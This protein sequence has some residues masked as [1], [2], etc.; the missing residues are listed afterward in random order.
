M[1]RFIRLFHLPL[2]L[3]ISLLQVVAL[4]RFL[5]AVPVVIG[6]LLE[7]R[8]V[9]EVQ[10]Q[11]CHFFLRRTTACRLAAAEREHSAAPPPEFKAAILC[12][13]RLHRLVV[14]VL[15]LEAH[16]RRVAAVRVV[17]LGKIN[18]LELLRHPLKDSS[19]VQVLGPPMVAVVGL[20]KQAVQMEIDLEAMVSPVQLPAHRFF[21]VAVVPRITPE[22]V[23]VAKAA[24]VQPLGR[25]LAKTEPSIQE[26]VEAAQML[27]S[28]LLA[29]AA[30]ASSFCDIPILLQSPSA[31]V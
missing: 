29:A 25:T 7:Q 12:S 20:E 17:A 2:L 18:P 9:E 4:A 28:S 21:V 11:H 16:R 24:A 3:I 27:M 5:V 14:A 26:A 13:A 15:V 1:A 22:R 10:N 19:V 30:Q 31:Q 6:H 8:V 23:A